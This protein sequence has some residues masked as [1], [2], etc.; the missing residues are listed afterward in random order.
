MTPEE[1]EMVFYEFG[2]VLSNKWLIEPEKYGPHL[3]CVSRAGLRKAILIWVAKQKF[4]GIDILRRQ[5]MPSGEKVAMLELAQ[6]IWPFASFFGALLQSGLPCPE[7][8]E[9]GREAARRHD[10]FFEFL[11]KLDAED[12][13]Y[14]H[15]VQKELE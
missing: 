7:S 6:N 15:K 10:R 11:Q 8:D 14:W 12:P 3:R 13:D 9:E 4:E 1:A 2:D 5:D